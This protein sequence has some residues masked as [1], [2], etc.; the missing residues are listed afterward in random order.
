MGR[1]WRNKDARNQYWEQGIPEDDPGPGAP[2]EE[3]QRWLL[4]TRGP[5][6][7]A[8]EVLEELRERT[9]A[10]P[11][12]TTKAVSRSL[13]CGY[14]Q[15]TAVGEAGAKELRMLNREMER[16]GRITDKEAKKAAVGRFRKRVESGDFAILFSGKMKLAI[17]QAAEDAELSTELGSV[18][19][20][21]ALALQQIDDPTQMSMAISRLANASARTMR[22]N[23]ARKKEER[24][25]G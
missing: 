20:A 12:C 10:M 17:D 3:R 4:K 19:I 16:L 22:A 11:E 15:S 23:T 24:Q 21:L 6:A 13:F 2:I 9:C 7:L 1:A 18:R 8:P 25:R 5:G 14:H